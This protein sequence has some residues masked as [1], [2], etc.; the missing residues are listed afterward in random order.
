M[1][2]TILYAKSQNRTLQIDGL[3]LQ[4]KYLNRPRRK[5]VTNITFLGW[6]ALRFYA[7]YR[8]GDQQTLCVGQGKCY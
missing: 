6:S 3:R 7:F 8:S 1:I 4:T 5:T 2:T